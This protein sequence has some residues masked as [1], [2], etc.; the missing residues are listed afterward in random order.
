[1]SM[2][3]FPQPIPIIEVIN[4]MNNTEREIYSVLITGANR[5]LG[6]AMTAEFLAGGHRVAAIN[7]RESKALLKLKESY[8]GQLHLFNGD[9]SDER[10]IEKVIEKISSH[11]PSIDMLIN[12]AAVHLDPDAPKIEDVDFSVYMQTFQVNSVAPLMVIKHALPLVRIGRKKLI[13]NVSSE[14]GSI[15]NAWRKSEYAY[16]MSK[17]ALNMA[18]RIL[19]NDL[20][21][22]GIKVLALHPG[23][24]SS[25]MGGA[26][27][28]IT[29]ADAAKKIIPL[30]LQ[31][32]DLNGPVYYDFDGK[33]ME[34]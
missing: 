24:F 23:W 26:E 11:T 29:P 28:P 3:V 5:G 22:E 7:R 8:R 10:L 31:S 25:D 6:L 15:G 13:V 4:L 32:F 14:A 18:S 12:N 27:A 34:W 2:P 19:Q 21:S 30:L 16:C 20:L 33:V 17:A 9:V 1:M